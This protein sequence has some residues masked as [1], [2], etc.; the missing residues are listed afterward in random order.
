M[1]ALHEPEARPQAGEEKQVP[2][3]LAP[4]P[5]SGSHSSLNTQADCHSFLLPS[6]LKASLLLFVHGAKFRPSLTWFHLH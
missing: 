1:Q 4:H 3:G 5:V 2:P 6:P